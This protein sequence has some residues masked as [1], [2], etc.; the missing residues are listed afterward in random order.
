MQSQRLFQ[1]VTAVD[2]MM[3]ES[4]EK[5]KLNKPSGKLGLLIKTGVQKYS[6]GKGPEEE[7]D[8]STFILKLD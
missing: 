7:K 4:K 2:D 5:L 8:E 1:K 3:R 6:M